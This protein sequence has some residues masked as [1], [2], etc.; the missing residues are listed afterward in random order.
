M[1][2]WLTLKLFGHKLL[3]GTRTSAQNFTTIHPELL[4]IFEFGAKSRVSD[5]QTDWPCRPLSRTV[6]MTEN[7]PSEE[8][9][10]VF[11]TSLSASQFTG[12]RMFSQQFN[13]VTPPSALSTEKSKY[14]KC[15]NLKLK[16]SSF[17]WRLHDLSHSSACKTLQ[18][19]SATGE[20][21]HLQV[22]ERRRGQNYN[23]PP[24]GGKLPVRV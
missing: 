18:V 16:C 8:E 10:C 4:L 13:R 17:S 2:V 12:L 11:L 3:R 24:A 14:L 5:P 22:T 6:C 21:L 19:R 23:E 7:T 20:K 15:F 9:W 1:D